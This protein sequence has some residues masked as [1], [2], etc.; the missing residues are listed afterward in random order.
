MLDLTQTESLQQWYKFTKCRLNLQLLLEPVPYHCNSLC[1]SSSYKD[2]TFA[3]CDCTELRAL[4]WEEQIEPFSGGHTKPPSFLQPHLLQLLLDSY[5]YLLPTKKGISLTSYS[6]LPILCPRVYPH[7]STVPQ[8]GLFLYY[9]PHLLS[10]D[11][12]LLSSCAHFSPNLIYLLLFTF[13]LPFFR[14]CKITPSF[15][16]SFAL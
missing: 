15:L 13:A 11:Y 4:G 5:S 12:P 10:S 8:N 2:E 1:K 7:S 9:S 16:I 3:R 6:F 14:S